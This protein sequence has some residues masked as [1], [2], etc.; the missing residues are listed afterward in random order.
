MLLVFRE[1]RWG[2][3]WADLKKL[4]LK[5]ELNHVACKHSKAAVEIPVC[6][7]QCRRCREALIWGIGRCVFGGRGWGGGTQCCAGWTVMYGW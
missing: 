7:R 2:L 4:L 1:G 3:L 5:V 6:Q